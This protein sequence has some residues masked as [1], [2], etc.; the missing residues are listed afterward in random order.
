MASTSVDSSSSSSSAR[1]FLHWR[2]DEAGSFRRDNGEGAPAVPPP[3]GF[4]VSKRQPAGHAG[5]RR[6]RQPSSSRAEAVT[7]RQRERSSRVRDGASTRSSL[8][9]LSGRRKSSS[10]AS[11]ERREGKHSSEG[12]EPKLAGQPFS[13]STC[14]F[15]TPESAF[16]HARDLGARIQ[17]HANLAGTQQLR[18]GRSPVQRKQRWWETSRV[19]ASSEIRDRLTSRISSSSSKQL[20]RATH[21]DMLPGARM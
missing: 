12:R 8:A 15:L 18:C 17:T 2:Q 9:L 21:C 6:D 10:G 3:A 20:S 16:H 4:L 1:G 7:T 19:N 11:A 14:F 5:G 13:R